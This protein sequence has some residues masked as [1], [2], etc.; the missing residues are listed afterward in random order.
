M[1]LNFA[2]L[3]ENYVNILKNHYADF[4]GRVRRREYWTFTLVSMVISAILGI[5]DS[6]LGSFGHIANLFGLAVLLPSL[7]LLARR[8]QDTGK[9]GWWML[10]GLTGIGGLVVLYFACI[11][12]TVGSNEFGEDTKAGER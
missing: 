12:G 7:G 3:K 10:L 4:K 5:V 8:L 6:F 11:D 9:S 2:T 1:E